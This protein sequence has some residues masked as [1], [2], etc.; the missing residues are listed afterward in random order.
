MHFEAFPPST[1]LRAKK[2][3]CILDD[4]ALYS[5]LNIMMTDL[6]LQTAQNFQH[7]FRGPPKLYSQAPGRINIIGE[8]TDY[9]GGLSLPAAIDCWTLCAWNP[10]KDDKIKI[11]SVN[12]DESW[13]TSWS[14][15]EFTIDSSWKKYVGGAFLLFKEA[16]L[17]DSNLLGLELTIQGNI[18]LGKGVSSSASIELAVLNGL[19]TLF[20]KDLTPLELVMMAQQVEHRFLKVKSGLLDQF[21][22]QFSKKD[23]ALL[24]DFTNL[25]VQPSPLASTF[26]PYTWILV[27]SM[28]TRELSNSKYSERVNE[29]GLIQNILQKNDKKNLREIS[30]PEVETLFVDAGENLLKRARHIVTENERTLKA[31]E[32]LKGGDTKHLGQ[33][34]FE[35]HESLSSD[36]E[37][38]HPNLDFLVQTGKK[39]PGVLGGRMMGGGFG[40]CCLF[41]V[42]KDQALSFSTSISQQ[43]E[44]FSQLK[45][46]PRRLSFVDGA[47]AWTY[48]N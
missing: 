32:C 38:S 28:V 9:T 3:D 4:R 21:A 14:E 20:K 26:E 24:I 11:Y 48:G 1:M 25:E 8:H 6:A 41:L 17:T 23:G 29:Y 19:N 7:R 18:P 36:Y 5:I 35:T 22:C 10:R 12:M 37:V 47:S 2:T 42:E 40:G 34:L 44:I 45:T 27:D 43:Y 16:K 15:L 33:L 31:F 30:S 39:I 46:L 13:E